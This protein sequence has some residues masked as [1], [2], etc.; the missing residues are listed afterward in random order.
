MSILGKFFSRNGKLPPGEAQSEPHTQAASEQQA[1][2]DLAAGRFREA[3]LQYR[4]LVT[5][6]PNNVSLLVSLGFALTRDGQPDAAAAILERAISLAQERGDLYYMLGEIRLKSGQRAEAI[7]LFENCVLR[8]P[9]MLFAHFD[10][11]KTLI[12]DKQFERAKLACERALLAQPD[13]PALLCMRGNL[14]LLDQDHLEAAAIYRRAGQLA[15][16]YYFARYGLGEALFRLGRGED[17]RAEFSRAVELQPDLPSPRFAVAMSY[18]NPSDESQMDAGAA[19]DALRIFEAWASTHAFDEPTLIAEWQPFL[20]GYREADHK[21]VIAHYG[22]VTSALMKRWQARHPWRTALPLPSISSRKIRLGVASSFFRDHS[23]WHANLKGLL[24][25]IDTTRFEVH[26]FHL[27][28]SYDASSLWAER[29]CSSFT[30]NAGPL[31]AWVQAILDRQLDA[32]IYPSPSIED[33]GWQLANLRLVGLQLTTWGHPIT[34]GVPTLDVYLSGELFEPPDAQQHYCE[35]LVLLP[36]LGACYT[37]YVNAD[38]ALELAGVDA[39]LPLLL[40]PGTPFK[41]RPEF[42]HVL[43]DI[44]K[45]LGACQL[46]FF[47]SKTVAHGALL[48]Q[49]LDAAFANAGL[50]PAQFIRFLPWMAPA[51]FHALMRRANV[52]LDTI[53]FSGFNTAVQAVEC[54]LPIVT[55]EGMFLRGRLASGVL[56]GIGL[57]ELVVPTLEDYVALAVRLVQDPLYAASIRTRMASQLANIT[58]DPQPVTALERLLTTMLSRAPD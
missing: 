40:C 42:D 21:Q 41:Y 18:L 30:R 25:L 2:A 6:A 35:R 46:L 33:L 32:M 54:G 15:P 57:A 28:E 56:R 22:R 38:D 43:I 19:I 31:Q 1:R 58:A 9:D 8:Q 26:V 14:Y 13:A 34:T 50:D 5:A 27:S 10:L 24:Q 47:R 16:D 53:G 51:A 29:H 48:E 4:Q 7:A 45:R 49:R 44:A 17:S 37:P 23:V 39:S 55:R 20:L 36:G 11:V 3:A 52:F 12:D